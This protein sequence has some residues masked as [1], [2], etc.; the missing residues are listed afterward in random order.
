MI[1]KAWNKS[2]YFVSHLKLYYI[3]KWIREIL[4]FFDIHKSGRHIAKWHF[5]YEIQKIKSKTKHPNYIYI[6]ISNSH[7][8]NV[9]ESLRIYLRNT[10]ILNDHKLQRVRFI[11]NNGIEVYRLG[12][13]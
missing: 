2:H 8:D 12:I 1:V 3:C 10:N 11:K 13:K 6:P 9:E 5:E 7:I 4:I